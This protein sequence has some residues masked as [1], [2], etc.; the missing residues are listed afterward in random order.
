MKKLLSIFYIFV[1][2]LP[3]SFA[4]TNLSQQNL[5]QKIAEDVKSAAIENPFRNVQYLLLPKGFEFTEPVQG[6]IAREITWDVFERESRQAVAQ[7]TKFQKGMLQFTDQTLQLFPPE[8]IRETLKSSPHQGRPDYGALSKGFKYIYIAEM[9]HDTATLPQEAALI[10]Q[11]IRAQNPNARILLAL[12]EAVLIEQLTIPL[13]PAEDDKSKYVLILEG[14]TPIADAAL[15]ASMDILA[16]DDAIFFTKRTTHY[17]KI[18]DTVIRFDQTAPHIQK[19]LTNYPKEYRQYPLE[20]VRDFLSR[21]NW[22][23][24]KRNEQWARYIKAVEKNYDIIV[25]FA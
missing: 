21:S 14:Y 1:F 3:L 4:Q 24:I 22:G 11:Q 19:L 2:V 13:V 12:E 17:L 9:C 7:Q 23:M 5:A 10:L 18:G 20:T 16:L 8:L 6:K 25:V 15:R